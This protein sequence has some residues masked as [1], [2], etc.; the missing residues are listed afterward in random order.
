MEGTP[1]MR[2]VAVRLFA[3][4]ALVLML[5]AAASAQPCGQRVMKIV[6]P[7]PPGGSYDIMARHI[8]HGLAERWSQQVVVENRSGGNGEV[9]TVA[10][11]SAPA[12][13]CTL[14]FWG[15]GILITQGLMTSRSFDALKSFAAVALVARTAQTLVARADFRA[16]TLPALIAASKEPNADIRYATAGIGTPG[17]LAIELLNAKSGSKLRHVPYRGGALALNDLISGQIDLVSTGLPALIGHIQSGGIIAL[18]VS[19]EKRTAVLPQ[20]PTM[21][22][23]V[24]GVFVDTWYGFLAPAGTPDQVIA[25]LHADIA[26]IMRAPTLVSRLSDQ[27]FDFVDLGPAELRS[28]MERDWPR[29]LEIIALAG[30][31]R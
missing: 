9:G 24:P 20:V 29:W 17:H 19:T 22:E 1:M 25:R 4:F 11:A 10:V 13:G 23:V 28:L 5:G 15:D 16:K 8:A 2:R 30:L 26:A 31:K 27:G 14:L 7:F 21:N 3:G 6:V 18:A 12:D